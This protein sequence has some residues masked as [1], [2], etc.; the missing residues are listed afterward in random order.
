MEFLRYQKILIYSSLTDGKV[1]YKNFRISRTVLPD[2]KIRPFN[3]GGSKTNFS[4]NNANM[5]KFIQSYQGKIDFTPISSY[6]ITK[7]KH[8]IFIVKHLNIQAKNYKKY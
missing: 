7:N 4:T 8:K 3:H 5:E 6:F 1:Q 2:A